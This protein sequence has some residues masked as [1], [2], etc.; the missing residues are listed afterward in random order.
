MRA[1]LWMLAAGALFS[2]MGAFGRVGTGMFAPAELLF[3]RSLIVLLAIAPR[4]LLRGSGGARTAHAGLHL[5]RSLAGTA[6][7]G[8]F[9]VTISV[10]PLAAAT[11]LNYTS[12]LFLVV[13]S[14]ALLGELP[15]PARTVAVALG[16]LGVALLLHPETGTVAGAG[17]FW[18]LATGFFTSLAHL[19]TSRLGKLGEPASRIVFYLALTGTLLA[20]AWT[21][22]HGFHPVTARGALILAGLGLAEALAQIAMARAYRDGDAVTVGTFAYSTVVFAS[23]LGL[24]FWREVPPLLGWLAMGIIVGSGVLA[25]R[26]SPAL[27]AAPDL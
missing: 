9:F 17:V 19:S 3:Y 5:L 11:T 8:S 25:G 23:I 21:A 26:A 12:P 10:I 14:A 4:A 15:G 1:S 16:F 13:L 22:L 18:G 20:F 27:D 7:A 24:I 6:A 2:L